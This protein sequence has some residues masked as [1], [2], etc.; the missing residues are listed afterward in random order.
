MSSSTQTPA[1][2]NSGQFKHL[3]TT[4]I[5]EL[6]QKMQTDLLDEKQQYIGIENEALEHI[7]VLILDVFN[8]ILHA[9]YNVSTPE[10][11]CSMAMSSALSTIKSDTASLT[12]SMYSPGS[13]DTHLTSTNMSIMSSR[14]EP[15]RDLADAEDRCRLT[16]PHHFIGK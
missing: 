7:G 10:I 12:G 13:S 3:L 5:V 14:V 9:N 8:S 1:Q 11:A 4:A 15:I 6:S 16:M 2:I